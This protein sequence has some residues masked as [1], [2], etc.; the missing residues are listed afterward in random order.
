MATCSTA[1]GR[2]EGGEQGSP[3][4]LAGGTRDRLNPV[5]AFSAPSLKAANFQ[6]LVS[7]HLSTPVTKTPGS[8]MW[9]PGVPS[10]PASLQSILG[11]LI[12]RYGVSSIPK[13]NMYLP[14]NP[15]PFHHPPPYKRNT[16]FPVLK[17]SE[18]CQK[19]TQPIH[20]V[21]RSTGRMALQ[22]DCLG[23]NL[24]V[25]NAS[26]PLSLSFPTRKRRMLIA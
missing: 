5:L 26:V 22:P 1:K 4:C 12:Q 9:L 7:D 17:F 10:S 21:I 14:K 23:S 2:Q 13:L 24:C 15:A 25:G 3:S 16:V 20:T 11:V 6:G 19:Q 18:T 8:W